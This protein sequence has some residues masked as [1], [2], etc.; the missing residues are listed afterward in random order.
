MPFVGANP[1]LEIKPPQYE[2]IDDKQLIVCTRLW[3]PSMM[4]STDLTASLT[5]PFI[6]S[7]IDSRGS[8]GTCSSVDESRHETLIMLLSVNTERSLRDYLGIRCTPMCGTTLPYQRS[9]TSA[10]EY[11][12]FLHPLWLFLSPLL[13]LLL[14]FP[15]T[16]QNNSFTITFHENSWLPMLFTVAVISI[17]LAQGIY[18]ILLCDEMRFSFACAA[19]WFMQTVTIGYPSLGLLIQYVHKRRKI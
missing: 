1:L 12:R 6:G 18:A 17:H 14:H 16:S 7:F 10:G 5:S 15:L 11:F 2:G 3:T 19:K 9:G 8:I 13:L 4:I